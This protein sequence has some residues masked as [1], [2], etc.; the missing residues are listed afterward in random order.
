VLVMPLAATLYR[1]PPV[2]A[3]AAAVGVVTMVGVH[4]DNELK[5]P[6]LGSKEAAWHLTR[7]EAQSLD[8]PDREPALAAVEREVP[9]D[10]ALAVA[11]SPSDWE[12][13]LY[14]AALERRLEPVDFDCPVRGAG[15][16]GLD[17]L[18]LGASFGWPGLHPG[19]SVDRYPGGGTLLVR[20][21]VGMR[22]SRL[23]CFARTWPR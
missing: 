3:A 2:A 17:Y 12:Y 22:A 7:A 9:G 13:P 5:P 4:V 10:A 15:R 11:L 18:F 23:P 8:V 1:W 16:R 14:G 6:G 21:G 19:W 20:R